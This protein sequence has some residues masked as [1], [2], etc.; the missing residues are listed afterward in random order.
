M[1]SHDELL[2]DVALLPNTLVETFPNTQV[3]SDWLSQHM[4]TRSRIV[5]S[6]FRWGPE[7]KEIGW[8]N[9]WPHSF[10]LET[11][12]LSRPTET[13]KLYFPMTTDRQRFQRHRVISR[14]RRPTTD[15][16]VINWTTTGFKMTVVG[17][18]GGPIQ[19]SRAAFISVQRV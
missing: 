1:F 15:W 7:L 14:R 13:N 2:I 8:T 12:R 3:V 4:C 18:I 10:V 5:C 6:D 11:N 16:I 19:V 9:E 17:T